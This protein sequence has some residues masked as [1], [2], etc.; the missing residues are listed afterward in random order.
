MSVSK[1]FPQQESVTLYTLE[2]KGAV[3]VEWNSHVPLAA[4][5]SMYCV[6]NSM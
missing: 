4:S 3:H 5:Y 6:K 1:C 2:T